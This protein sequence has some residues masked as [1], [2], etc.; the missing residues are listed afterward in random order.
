LRRYNAPRVKESRGV[1]IF[2]TIWLV[3]FI[4]LVIALW[5]AY[6]Y[7]AKIGS[8][9]R[10]SFKSN[11]GLVE[12]QSPIKMRDVTV[13]IVKK[14]SLSDDGKGV[15]IKARMN[16]DIGDYLNK[17]AKF[18]IVHPDVGSDGISGLDTI[19]SGS[20]IQLKGKKDIE[21][22]HNYIG[23]EK[24]PIDDE[25]KG[26]YLILSAPQSY[27]IR[28]KSHIYYRM[29]EI[30]RV[31]RVGISPDGSHV[32]F[33]IFIEEEYMNYINSKSKFYTRSAFNIDFSKGS[34]D[35]SLA[36][37]SQL[38]HGGISVYTPRGSLDKNNTI[39]RGTIFPLYKS[40]AQMKAKQLGIGG[41][42]RVYKLSFC[43]PT[44]K[45]KIGSPVEFKG[46]QVGYVTQIEDR[47]SDKNRTITSSVY[48]LLNIEAF[49]SEDLNRSQREQIL[50]RLVKRGLKAKL[51]T[52]MPVIGSQ[53]I[54]L[55]FDNSK[56]ATIVKQD[57]YEIL[58]T[59]SN[60]LEYDIME[61]VKGVLTKLENLPLEKLLDSANSLVDENRK[62]INNLIK[63]L[64][65]T[66]KS[67][68]TTV[69]NLNIFTANEEFNR[70]PENLN[71]TL[72]ELENTLQTLSND[73]SGDSQFADQLSITLKA[74]SE[75]A[76]SFDKTNKMLDRKAN[77]LVIGDE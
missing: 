7:Y 22:T 58:P 15:I 4:A 55:I 5:L 41:E 39:K 74:V 77:A 19:V 27:N 32:N 14:I 35:M 18:W 33:T 63:S 6:Q 66:V 73:Y 40:L 13:G 57:E 60:K 20:Y 75:A 71:Q 67:F 42:Q 61:Q 26:T 12:N 76:K 59:I 17:E 16:K 65:K 62:P 2:T 44:T 31:E 51:S 43:E 3:P 28:E 34:L 30:G 70:L 64:D 25:A 24:Q 53:F 49:T 45:L 52:P 68:N 23:L 72:Q 37:F 50:P 10:I 1:R 47:Y 21:T 29:M 46:F 38:L 48:T 36:P 9:I 11:A 8:T 56:K 54:E 69:K